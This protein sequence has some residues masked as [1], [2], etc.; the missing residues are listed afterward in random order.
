MLEGVDAEDGA[1]GAFREEEEGGAA[2][3]TLSIGLSPEKKK[4]CNRWMIIK[5]RFCAVLVG[6]IEMNNFCYHTDKVVGFIER[7]ISATIQTRW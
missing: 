3:M 4:L 6:L 5:E 2:G 7:T 1:K